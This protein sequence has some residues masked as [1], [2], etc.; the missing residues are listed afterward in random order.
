[1]NEGQKQEM[2]LLKDDYLSLNTF[3]TPVLPK[4]AHQQQKVT[5]SALF[6]LSARCD[7]P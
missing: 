1:M 4:R 7:L 2:N 3:F 5:P 6:P